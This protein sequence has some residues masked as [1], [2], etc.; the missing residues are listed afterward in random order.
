[1]TKDG[2]QKYSCTPEFLLEVLVFHSAAVQK[3]VGQR[4]LF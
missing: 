1:M 2:Q 4:L 3:F